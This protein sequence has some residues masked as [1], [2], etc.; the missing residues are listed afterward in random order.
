MRQLLLYS[1]G[2][3]NEVPGLMRYN[4]M[5]FQETQQ[6]EYYWILAVAKDL[7]SM[8]QVPL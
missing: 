8:K 3:A 6:F 5:T 7:N 4:A 2:P 1:I